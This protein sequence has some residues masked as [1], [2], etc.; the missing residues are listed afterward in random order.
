M[1]R[2]TERVCVE[3]QRERVCGRKEVQLEGEGG[4]V[5]QK[6]FDRIAGYYRG[7]KFLEHS[8]PMSEIFS[9]QFCRQGRLI[10]G[11]AI[12]ESKLAF[13][14]K[15]EFYVTSKFSSHYTMP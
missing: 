1:C 11:P 4:R 2:E 10:V 8:R 15:N 9:S 13:A 7:R 6:S 3:R 5:Q 14:T 12:S